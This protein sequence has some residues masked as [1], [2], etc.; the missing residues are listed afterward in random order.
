[1]FIDNHFEPT[2]EQATY[3]GLPGSQGTVEG[4]YYIENAPLLT[5]KPYVMPMRDDE[6]GE[7]M[8]LSGHVLDLDGKPVPSG[9]VK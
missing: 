9:A 1:M 6:P 3:D 5:E 7:A 4:P 2:V 8:V